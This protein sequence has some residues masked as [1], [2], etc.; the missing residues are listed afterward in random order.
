[1]KITDGKTA[2]DPQVIVPDGV[3][4]GS[5]GP[6]GREAVPAGDRVSVSDAAR[7][8]ARLRAEVGDLEATGDGRVAELRAA[9]AAGRYRVDPTAVAHSVL[10]A[11][12]SDHV[13]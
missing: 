11:L 9:V 8:L 13:R 2:L 4:G 7:D 1:M 10:R 6:A 12:L 5:G 3:R